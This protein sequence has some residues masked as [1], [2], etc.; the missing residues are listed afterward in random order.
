MDSKTLKSLKELEKISQAV[1]NSTD[2]VQGGGGNT[3]VKLDEERMAVKASGYSLKQIT[4]AEGFVVVNYRNI[5]DFYNHVDLASGADYEKEGIDFIMNNLI[6]ME[7]IKKLRPSVEAGFHS[8]LKKFVIH[9]HSVYANIL[10]CSKEGQK[11]VGKIFAGRPCACLWIPYV[12]PGFS[13]T[14]KIKNAIEESI[15]KGGAYPQVLFMENHGLIV[16]SEDWEDCIALHSEVNDRIKKYLG[17]HEAYPELAMETAGKDLYISRTPYLNAFF[18]NNVSETYFEDN[19]LYPDQLVY[20]NNSLSM[21]KEPNKL[22][23]NPENGERIYRTGLNEAMAI[24]E[25]LLGVI[26]VIQK[27]KECKLTLRNMPKEGI[28]F[29][30]NWESEK[31]RKSVAGGK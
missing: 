5:K 28:Y 26:Y 24:E 14:L 9:T 23:V 17:I 19:I 25:T 4:P 10:C 30:R 8:L 15:K 29:I 12:N 11:L 18:K 16:H 20:L 22:N 6:D 2:F 3:S 31:Y 27:V 21:D 1:G 13:L 7:G